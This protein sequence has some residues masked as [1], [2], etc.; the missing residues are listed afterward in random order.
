MA[1][2]AWKPRALAAEQDLLDQQRQHE[3]ALAEQH[4]QFV[5]DIRAVHEH[6]NSSPEIKA[7]TEAAFLRGQDFQQART[8]NLLRTIS[9]EVHSVFSRHVL[10]LS[11]IVRD[12]SD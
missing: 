5:R 8:A 7:D 12:G 10:A 6:Y 11:G 4:I 1:R 9:N 2:I 3:N